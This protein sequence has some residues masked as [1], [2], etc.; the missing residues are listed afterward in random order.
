MSWGATLSYAA[1]SSR[2]ERSGYRR[3]SRLLLLVNFALR[4]GLRV[5]HRPRER[6][7]DQRA[8]RLVLQSFVTPLPLARARP[9]QSEAANQAFE[10]G[11]RLFGFAEPRERAF[12]LGGVN[13]ADPAV[14]THP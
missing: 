1:L 4:A 13:Q 6:K 9:R 3:R 8:L 14:L 2:P 7:L 12:M 11:G 10:R 5:G